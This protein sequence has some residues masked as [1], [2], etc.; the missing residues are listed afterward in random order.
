MNS[1]LNGTRSEHRSNNF[2]F[3][4]LLAAVSVLFSHCFPLAGIKGLKDPL[5]IVTEGQLDFGALGVMMFFL[6]SG[7]LITQSFDCSTSVLRFMKA[8]CLRVFPGLLVVLS[9]SVFILGPSITA[10]PVREYFRDPSTLLYL[11][12]LFLY[13]ISWTLPGVFEHNSYKGVVNGSLWSIPFEFLY[14][15]LVASL[16]LLRLHASRF[17]TLFLVIFAILVEIHFKKF[18][19]DEN[20][21]VLQMTCSL[22]IHSGIPFFCGM[23]FYAFREAIVYKPHYAGLAVLIIFYTVVFGA[24]YFACCL[25]GCYL[26]FY[27]AFHG[28][29]STRDIARHGDL[30]YGI[31]LYAFPLQQVVIHLS[32]GVLSPYVQFMVSLP[33][34][35]AFAW[36]SWHCV[37]KR[38]LRLKN[39]RFLPCFS[40]P[41]FGV[42]FS[43]LVTSGL[44]RSQRVTARY[45][46]ILVTLLGL[47]ASIC[48]GLYVHPPSKISFPHE[49]NQKF[50]QGGW[51]PQ[52]AGEKYRW[53]NGSAE[54]RLSTQ[55]P[56]FK[57]K[58]TG[59]VP[60][61]FK[62]VKG[63]RVE[64]DGTPIA[65]YSFEAGT[66]LNIEVPC[67]VGPFI[68][69]FTVRLVFDGA[70]KPEPG[71][72]DQRVMSALIS[73]IS[74]D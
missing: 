46:I 37:E 6:I 32:G 35:L 50:L 10:L 42:R 4:R 13:N 8:R 5:E 9:L 71:D 27:F 60:P 61:S 58:I 48:Y 73:G 53:L 57:L 2:D 7:Y 51:L 67:D 20:A 23:L 22:L 19:S 44:V 55:Q 43:A 65:S 28:L 18:F 59:Y 31:Y 39:V 74:V 16:G 66:P 24:L 1:V 12:S 72:A 34:A 49:G 33:L 11:R 64:I 69:E 54:V 68:H 29:R 45:S 17:V 47:C 40:F 14:Y 62:Q 15:L 26:L 30:S 41:R 70:Y 3:L 21:R 52:L 36:A 25:A 63:L 38:A 56:A